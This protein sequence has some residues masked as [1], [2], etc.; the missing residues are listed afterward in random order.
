[1][2]IEIREL[3]VRAVVGRDDDEKTGNDR[4]TTAA[5][6]EEIVEEC[7]EQVME[8]LRRMRER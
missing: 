1:M 2:P 5:T 6:R 8:I 7:V 4:A 3:V